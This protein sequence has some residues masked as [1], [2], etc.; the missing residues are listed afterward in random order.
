META[1]PLNTLPACLKDYVSWITLCRMFILWRFWSGRLCFSLKEPLSIAESSVGLLSIYITK[2]CSIKLSLKYT[3]GHPLYKI[4]QG[5]NYAI[6]SQI[7]LAIILNFATILDAIVDFSVRR[8][9]E[10]LSFKFL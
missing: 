6:P 7:A 4:T 8:R 10:S 9:I 2:K 5:S 1:L 3:A